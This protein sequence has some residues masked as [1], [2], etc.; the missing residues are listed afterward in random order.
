MDLGQAAV[1]Q[2]HNE[3]LTAV[4]CAELD[5]SDNVSIQRFAA[6][7]AKLVPHIDILVNNAAIAFKG[8]DPT[9]FKEQAR[10]TVAVNYFGTLKVIEELLPLL[11]AAAAPRIVNLCSQAGHLRIVPSEIIKAELMSE[12][13]TVPRL[14]ELMN[15]FVDSVEAGTQVDNGWPNTCYGTSKLGLMA[16]TRVLARTNPEMT[17]N[18]CCPGYCATDMSS[19]KGPRS[20]EEGAKTPVF[21][22][23]TS[24]AEVTGKFFYD[25]KEL[26]W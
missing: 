8:S 23:L 12:E 19:H 7:M 21:L 15:Q 18:G 14:N 6:V 9:P 22:S 3:G 20:A 5:I 16:L 11:K 17:I 10:P 4:E 25:S 24:P 2:L 26:E 13:L 1:Q